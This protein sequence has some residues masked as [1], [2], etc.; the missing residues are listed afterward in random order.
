[1]IGFAL[2]GKILGRLQM[3]WIS[4]TTMFVGVSQMANY[5]EPGAYIEE[6]SVM[7]EP[8]EGVNTSTVAFIGGA[9]K[10][11]ILEPTLIT[12]WEQFEE[13]FGGLDYSG[14]GCYLAHAVDLFFKNQGQ[15]AYVVRVTEESSEETTG[16]TEVA[17]R[18]GL[19]CLEALDDINIVAMPDGTNILD[20]KAL[21]EHCEK[22]KFRFAVLDSPKDPRDVGDAHDVRLQKTKLVSTKG[23]AAIYYPWLQVQDPR[24]KRTRIVPPSGAVAG[25][26][27]RSDLQKGV[28]K[29]PTNEPVFGVLDTEV[30]VDQADQND[31]GRIGINTIRKFTGR[32]ILV[33]GSKTT[34]SD[35]IWKYV[36]VRRAV[37]Y[38]EQSII[39]GTEWVVYE[40]HDEITWEEAK[41]SVEEFLTKSLRDGMLLG[42]KP[43][44]A[45]IVRCDRTTMTQADIDKERLVIEVGV[46]LT[47][48]SEFIIFRVTHEM[49]RVGPRKLVDKTLD[50]PKKKKHYYM[51][52]TMLSE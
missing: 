30:A 32:G 44:E 35:S 34:S 16:R 51:A 40:P 33:W 49:E 39:K 7:A 27:A 11:P 22:M 52:R 48:P 42:T 9:P 1:M 6:I 43:Q 4:R 18:T 50:A 14:K 31:L 21:V 29:A 5:S 41:R 46:A 23:Y 24:T 26:F 28:Q 47:R 15:R 17:Y 3:F 19:P 2:K 38:L 8:I 20:Q 13:K 45:F 36:H 37:I 10:G 25:V 12:D